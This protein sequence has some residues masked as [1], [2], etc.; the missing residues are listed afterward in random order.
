MNTSSNTEENLKGLDN[1]KLK[2]EN[3]ES[4]IKEKQEENKEIE[5][6]DKIFNEI[7]TIKTSF[8]ESLQK[9]IENEHQNLQNSQNTPKNQ[10]V[11]AEYKE[12]YGNKTSN[13]PY[14]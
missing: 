14:L 11:S 5:H 2:L 4:M 1:F 13:F 6:F 12:K 9:I 7:G 8:N 10:N 3:L